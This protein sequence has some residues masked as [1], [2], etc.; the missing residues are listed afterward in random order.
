MAKT[1]SSNKLEVLR[2]GELINGEFRIDHLL[3]QSNLSEVYLA[4][5]V[6]RPEPV[7]IK[8]VRSDSIGAA[9]FPCLQKEI[10]ILNKLSHPHI[11]QFLNSFYDPEERAFGIVTEYIRGKNVKEV[12]NECGVLDVELCVRICLQLL[13]ALQYAHL[14]NII[15]CDLK[16]ANLILHGDF[17]EALDHPFLKVIDFGLGKVLAQSAGQMQSQ[18]IQGRG[19]G[20]TLAYMPPEGLDLRESVLM[21]HRADLYSLGVILFELLTG[22]A[23]FDASD[24]GQL[25]KDKKSRRYPDLRELRADVPEVLADIID[26]LLSANPDER[27]NSAS[28]LAEDL[29][30]LY[31]LQQE[32]SYKGRVALGRHD[33][34][35]PLWDTPPL[36]GRDAEL[37][38]LSEFL[39][40]TCSGHGNVLLTGGEAGIGKTRLMTEFSK[41]LNQRSGW[42]V[43]G[44][45]RENQRHT[46]YYP[47]IECANDLMAY[48]N[49]LPED[50]RSRIF[51]DVREAVNDSAQL[52][53]DLLP[54]LQE[55]IRAKGPVSIAAEQKGER[56]LFA[57]WRL[58]LALAKSDRPLFFFIDDL[59]WADESTL[60]W[61][62]Y[63]FQK[64]QNQ[65]ATAP[66]SVI[67]AY[68]GEAL[69]L[70]DT[71][72]GRWFS[73]FDA[74]HFEQIQLAPLNEVAVEY[75][76]SKF[77]RQAGGLLDEATLRQV[78][79]FVQTRARGNPFFICEL[80]KSLFEEKAILLEEGKWRCLP[81][82]INALKVSE[83]AV[84]LVLQRISHLTEEE[85]SILNL[86][87]VFG[88]RFN[89]YD[90]AE[91]GSWRD[92]AVVSAIQKG[93]NLHMIAVDSSSTGSYQFAH[94]NIAQAFYQF[95]D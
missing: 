69:E 28:G 43:T 19:M 45:C 59:Q 78:V 30:R 11:V 82:R 57:F 12:L 6:D 36:A 8:L 9:A 67:A 56:F 24:P 1:A 95:L 27:Y 17:P 25:I 3:A 37:S 55:M 50:E 70:G 38:Q 85:Q 83:D 20:G 49:T 73:R 44:K 86:A 46:P 22:K 53:A 60:K 75:L 66:L 52:I 13:D 31:D 40:K 62:E 47:L 91:V 87:S 39:E 77:F 51:A 2:E 58:A 29:N 10:D 64:L 14:R 93:R 26:K 92:E 68:R 76:L 15:H 4:T 18:I 42:F 16:P 71:E 81:D 84:G 89:L 88:T 5:T 32:R 79:T 54:P 35:S 48:F 23:P 90:V 80:M 65:Q 7:I 63:F 72:F 41:S 33:T 94:D 34:S 61:L 74:G 21:D